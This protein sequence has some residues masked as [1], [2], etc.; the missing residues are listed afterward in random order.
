MPGRSLGQATSDAIFLDSNAAG[1]GRSLDDE[2]AP[3]EVDLLSVDLHELGHELGLEHN[4]AGF[5]AEL[6]GLGQ[7]RLPATS[8]TTWPANEPD[9][10]YGHCRAG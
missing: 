10:E 4:E 2:V 9:Q 5:M 7:R 3:D 1:N 6:I 8:T